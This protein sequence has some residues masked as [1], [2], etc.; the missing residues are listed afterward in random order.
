MSSR[1][2]ACRPKL[3]ERRRKE[4]YPGSKATCDI[5]PN[6]SMARNNVSDLSGEALAKTDEHVQQTENSALD[7]CLR[8]SDY[9]AVFLF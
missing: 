9:A 1:N 6:T 7:S 4:K 5:L 2:F 8:R 3:K